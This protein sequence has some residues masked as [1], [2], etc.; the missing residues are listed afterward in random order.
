MFY[1]LNKTTI[2]FFLFSGSM[3]RS[4]RRGQGGEDVHEAMGF[5]RNMLPH[6]ITLGL[7]GLFTVVVDASVG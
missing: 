7:Q 5:T 3:S 4:Q 1:T 6:V 2:F